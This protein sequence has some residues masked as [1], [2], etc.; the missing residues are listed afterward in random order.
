MRRWWISFAADDGPLGAAITRGATFEDALTRTH[1]LG[2]NPGGEALG[3]DI[4]D[5]T[6]PPESYVD[7]LLSVQ[8]CVELDAVLSGG[9]GVAVRMD[10]NG[11][12][13]GEVRGDRSNV[14]RPPRVN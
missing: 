8:D 7:R 14:E 13:I 11:K 2:I 4:T 5:C 3:A 6:A 12:K 9:A 1:A 10:S